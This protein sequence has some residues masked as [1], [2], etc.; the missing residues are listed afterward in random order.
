MKATFNQRYVSSY[1]YPADMRH[2]TVHGFYRVLF[3]DCVIICLKKIVNLMI[4]IMD[5]SKSNL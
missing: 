4:L 5:A 3:L 2:T 1:I